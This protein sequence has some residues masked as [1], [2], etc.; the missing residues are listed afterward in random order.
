MAF[1]D[2]QPSDSEL[3][4]IYTPR[5]FEPFGLK[6]ECQQAYRGMKRAWFVRLLGLAEAYAAPS[7]LLDVGSGPGDLLAVGRSRGWDVQGIEPNPF[8]VAVSDTVVP[9]ATFQGSLAD[10]DG[11]VGAFGLV[12]CCDVLEHVRDPSDELIRMRRALRPGGCVLLTT[13]DSAGWQA[14]LTGARWIHYLPEHLWYFNR[15]SLTRLVIQ[16]GLD[17]VHWEVPR[18]VFNLRYILGIFAH[19]SSSPTWRR[20]WD[21][22]LRMIPEF[23][24]SALLPGLP[25]GQLLIAKKPCGRGV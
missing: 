10:F 7:R 4:A 15:E 23:A 9:G 6:S 20:V 14:R 12:T 21:G 17:V 19:H 8:A 3:A 16:A 1:A 22:L 5:Y 18:K 11:H 13:I 24:Q 25:E 2:P